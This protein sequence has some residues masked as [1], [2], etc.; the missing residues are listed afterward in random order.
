MPL[1]PGHY[2]RQSAVCQHQWKW[3]HKSNFE[4][5]PNRGA[6]A[7]DGTTMAKHEILIVNGPNLGHLGQRQPD[8]YGSRGM[9]DVPALVNTLLGER[10]AQVSLDFFQ[11]NGEGQLIDR[12][13]QAREEGVAGIVMNAGAYTHTS[14]ALADCL[15][16]IGI[17]CVE[18]HISNVWARPE[19]IRHQSYMAAQAVGVI[20]GFGIESYA[21]A[22]AALLGRLDQNPAK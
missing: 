20:A 17:P 5:S 14:L 4:T 19:T 12:L 9:G 18:V 1:A 6:Q 22:V 15:A 10:A 16:W 13:E 3:I 7:T 21:L 2:A 8:I 11:A